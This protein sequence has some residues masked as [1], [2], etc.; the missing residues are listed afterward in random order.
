MGR[1]RHLHHLPR[2]QASVYCKDWVKYCLTGEI[3]TDETDL[4]GINNPETRT[5]SE[6]VIKLIGMEDY[7]HLLP[8]II[9]SHEIA[10]YHGRGC[11]GHRPEEGH[12]RCLRCLGLF[13]HGPGRGRC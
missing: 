10:G 7:K 8:P 6:E 2:A 3:S 1:P 5:Y 9:R 13:L 11:R 12:P 4:L